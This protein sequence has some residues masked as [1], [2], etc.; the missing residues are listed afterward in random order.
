MRRFIMVAVLAAGTVLGVFTPTAGIT[1][2][3]AD[4]PVH[5]ESTFTFENPRPPGAFCDF[6]Y[7][8]VAAR[9]RPG[10]GCI[11][12]VRMPHR[13]PLIAEAASARAV[14]PAGASAAAWHGK[15]TTIDVPGA[16]ATIAVS[17]NDFGVLG[18]GYTD[19][20]G[21]SH[22][23]ID[24]RAVFTAVDDPHAGT[25]SGQGTSVNGLNDFGV[26]DGTYT[27]G[28]GVSHGFIDRRGV[29]TTVDHA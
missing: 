17:V 11:M 20:T 8:E 21:V 10:R 18:G 1:A 3:W 4:G 23:F 9:A 19:A 29:F 14:M 2:A 28:N 6:N 15:Y 12:S 27:D 25:A 24:R 26:L 5:V 16:T 7:G 13:M 22:G